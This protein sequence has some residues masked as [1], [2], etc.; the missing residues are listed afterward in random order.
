MPPNV[1]RGIISYSHDMEATKKKKDVLYISIVEYFSARKRKAILPFAKT[2]DRPE[3][4]CLVKLVREQIV[5][6]ITH[7]WSLKK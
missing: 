3:V 5:Y 2:M 1:H 6:V 4:I 7:I